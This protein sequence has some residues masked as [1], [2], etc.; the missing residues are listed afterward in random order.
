MTTLDV[1]WCSS[2]KIVSSQKSNHLKLNLSTVMAASAIKLYLWKRKKILKFS[3]SCL[4]ILFLM[5]FLADFQEIIFPFFP[6][7]TVKEIWSTFLFF[8]TN[9]FKATFR[10]M[11]TGLPRYLLLDKI[12]DDL[13]D[14]CFWS[15]Y[16]GTQ[17][18]IYFSA[19]NSFQTRGKS[20]K[21]FSRLFR[22]LA[23]SS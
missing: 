10:V 8:C 5:S 18:N 9:S 14:K 3:I 4:S 17:C 20:Y 1:W 13:R 6:W 7:C 21:S 15:T 11:N 12:L 22:C 2:K 16:I 23:Q 19:A